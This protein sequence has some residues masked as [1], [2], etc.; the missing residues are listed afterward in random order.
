VRRNPEIEQAELNNELL[1]LNNKSNR[2]FVMNAAA[3]VIWEKLAQSVSEQDLVGELCN[4]FRGV[5]P[6]QALSDV[7]ETVTSMRELDLILD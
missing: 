5:T 4:R 1:L 6:D 2:F 7:K 3:A